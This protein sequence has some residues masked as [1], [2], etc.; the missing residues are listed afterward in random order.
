MQRTVISGIE[1]GDDAWLHGHGAAEAADGRIGRVR[2]GAVLMDGVLSSVLRDATY[3]WL[4]RLEMLVCSADM[5]S[6][7]ALA[8]AEM[9]RLISAWRAL[10]AEHEPNEDG[11]CRRCTG[12]RRHRRGYRCSVWATAHRHLVVNDAVSEGPGRHAMI[13]YREGGSR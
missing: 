9:G 5:P 3:G 13:P 11:R 12:R 4:D 7:A 6:R 2:G 1:I 8:D 10:L